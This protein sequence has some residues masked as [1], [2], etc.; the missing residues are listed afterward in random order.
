[1]PEV[2]LVQLCVSHSGHQMPPDSD[3]YR[4]L[5]VEM[6]EYSIVECSKDLTCIISV[7]LTMVLEGQ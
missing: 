2:H 6:L 3:N 4:S 7:I 1:M 5:L